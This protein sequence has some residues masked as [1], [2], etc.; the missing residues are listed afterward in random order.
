M[1]SETDTGNDRPWR[2]FCAIEIPEEVQ[3]K[4]GAHISELRR[5]LPEM[6]A[7]WIRPENIH[8]TLKFLGEIPQ[9]RVQPLSEAT[10]R[11]AS[12]SNPFT[13]RL[14]QTGSFPPH[15]PARVLWIG[16]GDHEGRL[17]HLHSRLEGECE[18]EGFEKEA[19]RFHPHLTVARLRKPHGARTLAEAHQQLEFN[20]AEIRVAEL[21]VIRSELGR[22]GSKY[23]VISSHSL[24]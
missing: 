19:R 15:G 22:N 24:T 16:I 1:K 12:S 11:A 5:A 2:V 6:Q 9:T 20:P 3:E 23:T 8:L 10:R 4:L 17:A 14:E 7:S 21:L 13:I 18:K